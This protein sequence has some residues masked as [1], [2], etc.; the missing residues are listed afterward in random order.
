M[1]ARSIRDSDLSPKVVKDL[2]LLRELVLGY[3]VNAHT[4]SFAL[5]YGSTARKNSSVSDLDMLIV[6]DAPRSLSGRSQ[7]IHNL[8]ALHQTSGRCIDTEVPYENKLFYGFNDLQDSFALSMFT[9]SAGRWHVPLL[10][11]LA[12]DDA[13]FASR[14]MKLRLC[15]NA[16]TST[17]V[18]IAGNQA[19]YE[20]VCAKAE[21]ALFRVIKILARQEG[22]K[23]IDQEVA[24]ELLMSK[25]GNRYKDYLGYSPEDT[26]L[27][28]TLTAL[29]S[30]NSDAV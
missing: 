13:Y 20:S 7:F 19:L 29:V 24:C 16:F 27:M 14:S 23:K 17:H 5:C 4:E 25:D 12:D 8:V 18:F 22:I 28:K 3:G 11:D 10:K 9:D 21:D 26:T 2:Q 30:D 1:L 15:L 6:E